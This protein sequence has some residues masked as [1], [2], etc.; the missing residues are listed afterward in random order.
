[1][2]VHCLQHVPFEGLG[3]IEPWLRAAGCD[4][5]TT[6]LYEAED[7]PAPDEVDLLIVLGGPM[8]VNDEATCPWLAEEKRFVRSCVEAP[9]HQPH[10]WRTCSCA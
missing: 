7:L 1:M 3:S 4:L 2:R 9:D 5:S 6:R 8:S 10:S